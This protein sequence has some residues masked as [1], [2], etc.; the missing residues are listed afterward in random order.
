MLQGSSDYESTLSLGK[1][2]SSLSTKTSLNHSL[3]DV[4]FIKAFPATQFSPS[5]HLSGSLY[6]DLEHSL[7]STAQGETGRTGLLNTQAGATFLLLVL[8][9]G[10]PGGSLCTWGPSSRMQE[11]P[12]FMFSSGPPQVNAGRLSSLPALVATKPEARLVSETHSK[13]SPGVWQA[14]N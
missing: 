8:L 5:P 11:L 12:E 1:G 3:C 2:I 13:I 10:V 4:L 7:C 9:P 14:L 6:P